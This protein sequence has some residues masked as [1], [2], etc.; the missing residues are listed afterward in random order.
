MDL[1]YS[2]CIAVECEEAYHIRLA[3]AD[4]SDG[5]SSYVFLEEKCF[6]LIL[7]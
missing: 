6:T 7:K 3:I 2:D 4:G 5:V 1:Q